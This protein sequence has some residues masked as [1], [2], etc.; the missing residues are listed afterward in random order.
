LAAA[1]AEDPSYDAFLFSGG[2]LTGLST[3][4]TTA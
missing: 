4:S 3:A 2:F 1:E